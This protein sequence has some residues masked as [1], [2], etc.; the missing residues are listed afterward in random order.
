MKKLKKPKNKDRRK[1]ISKAG[2]G[3]AMVMAW[4]FLSSCDNKSSEKNN[5]GINN[6]QQNSAVTEDFNPDI[7]IEL[8][9]GQSEIGV[10]AAS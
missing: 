4:P 2:S 10:L 9:A 1:F 8:N 5:S 3:A 7:D 6:G